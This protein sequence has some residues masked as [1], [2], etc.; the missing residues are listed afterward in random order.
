MLCIGVLPSGDL[1][2]RNITSAWEGIAFWRVPSP[3]TYFHAGIQYIPIFFQNF[4]PHVCRNLIQTPYIGKSMIRKCYAAT[5]AAAAADAVP[6]LPLLPM[7][8]QQRPA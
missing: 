1:E 6:I 3:S 7:I 4:I 2:C 8:K 5:I